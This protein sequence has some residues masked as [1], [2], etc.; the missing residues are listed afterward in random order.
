MN[1]LLE[2]YQQAVARLADAKAHCEQ[3]RRAYA[4]ALKFYQ[5]KFNETSEAESDTNANPITTES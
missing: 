3:A 4:G 5:D 1:G 2:Q